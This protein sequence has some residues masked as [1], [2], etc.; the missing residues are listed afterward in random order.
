MGAPV[1]KRVRL[2]LSEINHN[3][4]KKPDTHDS[5]VGFVFCI[6]KKE[7][8]ERF[9]FAKLFLKNETDCPV[10]RVL[11]RTIIYLCCLLPNSSKGLPPHCHHLK[12]LRSVGQTEFQRGVASDRVYMAQAVTCLSVSSYLAFPSLP[13]KTRRFISVA[14]SRESPPADVIRYP[15][16]VK[17]GLSSR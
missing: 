2:L 3:F 13:R 11:S 14:L 17:P 6:I 4:N 8:R 10:S 9:L 16:P 12:S 5:C 7:N 1:I 15:C